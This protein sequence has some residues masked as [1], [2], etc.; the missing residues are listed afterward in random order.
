M[1]DGATPEHR[2]RAPGA[3][4]TR[5]TKECGKMSHGLNRSWSLRPEELL[6]ESARVHLAAYAAFDDM[7]LHEQSH[8]LLAGSS[9]PISMR[10]ALTALSRWLARWGG[11]GFSA[12]AALSLARR[13]RPGAH[14][15]IGFRY[16]PTS[17]VRDECIAVVPATGRAVSL[18]TID[19]SNMREPMAHWPEPSSRR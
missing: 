14:S 15:P 1:H 11:S 8:T 2:W 9:T 13:R 3:G 17:A 10:S 18:R 7:A 6:I 19:A 16:H 4:L 12:T 5:I